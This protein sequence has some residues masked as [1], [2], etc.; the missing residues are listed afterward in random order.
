MKECLH[1][2]LNRIHHLLIFLIC[3]LSFIHSLRKA[4]E[5]DTLL[6]LYLRSFHLAFKLA[7]IL[8]A[9]KIFIVKFVGFVEGFNRFFILCV[10]FEFLQTI[11]LRFK[12][13]LWLV[14]EFISFVGFIV[15]FG[16]ASA[17]IVDDACIVK[18]LL[19]FLRVIFPFKPRWV[20]HGWAFYPYF[21]VQSNVSKRLETKNYLFGDFASELHDLSS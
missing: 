20:F 7:S 21:T 19:R 3:P 9:I 18:K 16:V 14:V 13:P 15:I 17:L 10:N 1:Q 2:L 8:Q 11:Q 6:C 4:S 12:F 5:V